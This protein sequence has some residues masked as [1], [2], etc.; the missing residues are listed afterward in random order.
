M[1]LQITIVPDRK[2]R[3]RELNAYFMAAAIAAALLCGPS[4]AAAHSFRAGLLVPLSGPSTGAGKQILDGF[5]LA[6][7]ERDAH[8]DMESDGHLGGLDVYLSR[9]NVAGAPEAAARKAGALLRREKIEFLAVFA[10][11]EALSAL[12]PAAAGAKV[13][14]LGLGDAPRKIAGKAC[15]PYFI[16]ISRRKG[17]GI[18]RA[19]AASFQKEYGRAP[20]R[21]AALGYDA[22]QLIDSAVRALGEELAD[23]AAL[24][25]ALRDSAYR[26]ARAAI[27]IAGG[28]ACR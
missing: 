18:G 3:K 8:P 7:K 19:F 1:A 14:L 5:M 27:V 15:P 24:R 21:L 4:G 17:M 28:P 6:T 22:A 23:R 20:S 9:I 11:P 2:R 16:S 12:Y 26:P 10:S 25:R 13:F